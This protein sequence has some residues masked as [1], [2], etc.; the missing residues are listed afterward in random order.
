M[1]TLSNIFANCFKQLYTDYFIE[2]GYVKRVLR[3]KQTRV[4][5]FNLLIC[6]DNS[7]D[8]FQLIKK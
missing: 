5:L 6:V 7:I 3:D 1:L 4:G 2:V 8:T